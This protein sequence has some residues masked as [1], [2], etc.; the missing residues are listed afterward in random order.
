MPFKT[1]SFAEQMWGRMTI[2]V[3]IGVCLVC[4]ECVG[5]FWDVFRVEVFFLC[6]PSGFV[7]MVF[8]PCVCRCGL[9]VPSCSCV[10]P[11]VSASFVSCLACVSSWYSSRVVICLLCAV[12]VVYRTSKYV[13]RFGKCTC[14]SNVCV[15]LMCLCVEVLI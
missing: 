14:V 9:G 10:R 7:G 6:T 8:V 1:P 3:V 2:T 5:V 4:I 15:C 13:S 12:S 11:R